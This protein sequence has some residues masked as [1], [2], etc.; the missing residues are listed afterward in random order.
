MKKIF[1]AFATTALLMAA[2]VSC[3]TE[4]TEVRLNKTELT[5]G[6]GETE[7]L[8]ATILPE[9]ADN[10][11]VNWKSSSD[12]VTVDDNGKITAKNTGT[13]LITV[14]TKDG[15][16]TA[17]CAVTVTVFNTKVTDVQLNKTE[18][19]LIVGETETLIATVLPEDADN[20]AVSWKSSDNNVAEVDDNGKIT[21]KDV[22]TALITVTTNGGGKTATC[23]LTVLY[24]NIMDSLIG[25]WIWFIK[26]DG[27][28]G[29]WDNEF[30]SI[31]L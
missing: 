26:S 16:K 15:E 24:G 4:V 21:A 20:K 13:A 29:I 3:K 31:E 7:T 1:Y 27:K 28:G 17:H 14:T 23:T 8:I 2:T 30:K 22:G 5:L 12:A 18:L 19:T 6:V 25:E 10:K 9:D 11:A